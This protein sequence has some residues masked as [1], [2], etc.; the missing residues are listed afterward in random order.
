MERLWTT[1]DAQKQ[2][3]S[4]S[5]ECS[6]DYNFVISFVNTLLILYVP[7]F[8]L[9]ISWKRFPKKTCRI[10]LGCLVMFAK[11]FDFNNS[12]IYNE[13]SHLH[14]INST[15]FFFLF[16]EAHCPD[17]PRRALMSAS[18]SVCVQS[19][20]WSCGCVST[21]LLKRF[22]KLQVLAVMYWQSKTAFSGFLKWHNA[23]V[24]CL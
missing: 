1:L 12:S 9:Y 19:A 16:F 22:A 18:I 8:A 23:D 10:I 3:W 6:L 17:E 5:G 15:H 14:R 7:S 2:T 11:S 20:I 21:V 24:V 4:I 13:A